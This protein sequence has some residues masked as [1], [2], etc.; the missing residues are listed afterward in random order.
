VWDYCSASASHLFGDSTGD[1]IADRIREA[2][3]ESPQGLSKYQIRR[4]F[5]GHVSCDRIDA[6]LEQ[7][8]ML[9]AANCHSEPTRGRSATLWSANAE[10]EPDEHQG[11]LNDL[12]EFVAKGGGL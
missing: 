6:A 2:L 5:H 11:F 1:A 12:E 10:Q 8:T 3:E 4:L 7:L 9:E